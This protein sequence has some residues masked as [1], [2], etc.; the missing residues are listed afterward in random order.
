MSARSTVIT[1]QSHLSDAK[2][3][4]T[5]RDPV[6]GSLHRRLADGIN[7]AFEH[8]CRHGDLDTA[9]DL[10]AVL[11]DQRDRWISVN[12]GER[13]RSDQLINRMK[14]YLIHRRTQQLVAAVDAKVP[15]RRH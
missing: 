3:P 1:A 4:H 14:D 6:T 12:G 11:E 7:A 15:Q 8:A 13:R 2:V 5:W 9:A 10:I